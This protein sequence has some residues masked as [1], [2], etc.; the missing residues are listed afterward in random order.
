M[1]EFSQ[2]ELDL[3]QSLSPHWY[4]IITTHKDFNPPKLYEILAIQ[5][6][7]ENRTGKDVDSLRR[8]INVLHQC[9]IFRLTKE[10]DDLIQL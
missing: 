2:K 6:F 8:I 7:A 10:F 3:I 9:K 1:R 5:C 4:K